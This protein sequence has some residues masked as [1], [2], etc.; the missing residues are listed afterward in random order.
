MRKESALGQKRTWRPSVVISALPP[1]A[2]V[3]RR[4]SHVRIVPLETLAAADNNGSHVATSYDGY[5]QELT[6]VVRHVDHAP[7]TSRDVIDME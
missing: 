5:N 2:D 6:F 1:K 4:L 7:R 3:D